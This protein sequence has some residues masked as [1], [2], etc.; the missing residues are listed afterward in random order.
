MARYEPTNVVTGVEIDY[1]ELYYRA[2]GNPDE[3]YPVYFFANDRKVFMS[4]LQGEGIYGKP[5]VIVDG[6]TT[7]LP[8]PDVSNNTNP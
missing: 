7:H 5:V 3:P 8:D 4:N 6:V 2:D 1:M